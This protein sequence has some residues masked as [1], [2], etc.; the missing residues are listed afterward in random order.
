MTN[1]VQIK[2]IKD[3]QELVKLLQSAQQQTLTCVNVLEDTVIALS[4]T[5]NKLVDHRK[6][7]KVAKQIKRK[8]Q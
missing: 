3:L 7:Q 8:R 6:A 1:V 5:E 2:M 4:D